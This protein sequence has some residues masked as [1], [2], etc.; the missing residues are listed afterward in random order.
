MRAS[1]V[2]QG[3]RGEIERLL[4]PYR[5]ELDVCVIEAPA[6]TT[7]VTRGQGSDRRQWVDRW[8]GPIERLPAAATELLKGAAIVHL[9]PV[10]R[11]T[12]SHDLPMQGAFL[13]LTPQGLVRTWGEDGR[14]AAAP[15]DPRALPPRL[16]AVVLSEAERASCAPLFASDRPPGL[17]AVTA[18]AGPTELRLPDGQTAAVSPLHVECPREDLGAGDV[19]AAAF[20]VELWRGSPAPLAARYAAAAAALRVRGLGP[21]AV[22]GSEEIARALSAPRLDM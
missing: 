6:T 10:A 9:A 5:D 1:I 15:L 2:T 4:A 13:G 18:G 8:A 19:F 12:R 22:A 7:L 16:D 14:I 21:G 11:E 17:I 20:F 3:V